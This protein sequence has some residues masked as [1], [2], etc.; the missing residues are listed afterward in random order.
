MNE[1]K[2]LLRK[3]GKKNP[4]RTPEGYFDDFAGKLMQQLP[5]TAAP[6]TGQTPER[7][8]TID[9]IKPWCY[10]AAMF[11][12]LLFSF[13]WIVGDAGTADLPTE[14]VDLVSD[15]EEEDLEPLM[16]QL[17]MD[18]YTLYQYLTEADADLLLHE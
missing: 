5:D 18:D 10:M 15:M 3:Y 4:Y 12:G 14:R 16:D 8:R 9:R 17:L 13:R 1:D 7:L 11:A 2:E 6:C